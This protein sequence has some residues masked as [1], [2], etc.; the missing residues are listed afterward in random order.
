MDAAKEVQTSSILG[1]DPE[2]QRWGVAV[3]SKWLAVGNV[4]PHARAGVGAI[5]TQ[6]YTNASFG[7][8]GLELLARGKSAQQTL[9]ELLASDSEP[10]LR[11]VGVLDWEGRAAVHTG[12]K[13]NLEAG[14]LAGT[15]CVVQG[16]TLTSTD[17]LQ[18]MRDTF[19]THSGDLAHKLYAALLAGSDA[20]GDRRG[21]Q[22]ASLLVV[23]EGAGYGGFSDRFID[24]RVDDHVEPIIELGRLLKM[25][26]EYH[27]IFK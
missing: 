3:A 12:S 9:D 25:H 1:Y 21:K 2:T 8:Q 19:E 17:V 5:A 26:P 27:F 13:C 23:Q 4:V 24:L 6:A 10:E 15:H 11:Q 14:G 22:S 7:P 20:G 18:V 16:N